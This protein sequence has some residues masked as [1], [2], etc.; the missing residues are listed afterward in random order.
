MIKVSSVLIF[1]IIFTLANAYSFQISPFSKFRNNNHLKS[2]TSDVVEISNQKQSLESPT[3]S[4]K[5]FSSLNLLQND[6]KL[7]YSAEIIQQSTGPVPRPYLPAI[8]LYN[9]V[10][11]DPKHKQAIFTI[12]EASLQWY[13]DHGGRISNLEFSAPSY[14]NEVAIE[15]GFSSKVENQMSS[16]IKLL[17]NR[18]N[19]P[20]DYVSWSSDA[21]SM[22][23][24][25]EKR[26][27]SQ[28][29]EA[30]ILNDIIGRLYHDSGDP[31]QS[32]D[33]YTKS[34]LFNPKSGST[35][36]NLG[37]AYQAIGNSQ[38]AFASF[39]QALQLNSTDPLTYLKLAFFY[40]DFATKDWVEAADNAEQCYKYYLQH[41]DPEDTSIL[42]RL[43]NLLVREHKPE[44]AIEV[45]NTIL[46]LNEG[47]Q[48]VWFNKAHAEI[49][50]GDYSAAAVSLKRTL[51]LDPGISAARHMLRALS[52]DEALAA[53]STEDE[54]VKELF[55]SY[56]QS[57]DDH[58]K[59]LLYSAPRVIRQEM[60][61]IYKAKTEKIAKEEAEEEEGE[62]EF[63][64][65]SA[66]RVFKAPTSTTL[67]GEGPVHSGFMMCNEHAL[68]S[69]V[70]SCTDAHGDSAPAVDDSCSTYT[71]FVN[72][73]LDILDL[74]CGTGLAGGW[75]KDYARTLV[76]VDLSE[77]MVNLAR[78]KML[79]Q[80]L[81]VMP[82]S[83]YLNKLDRTFDLVAAAD[84]ISY[85]GDLSDLFPK[86]FGAIKPGGHFIFTA[87]A[88]SEDSANI[89][90]GY[91]LLRNG[92]F[93]YSKSYIDGVINALEDNYSILMSRDYSPR[94][95]AGNPIPGYLYI[96]EK[97]TAV[98]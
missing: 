40:E 34:L 50:I 5:T 91:R 70:V 7:T 90:K 87:E 71:S 9:G 2:K 31:Q 1:F 76:G 29:G 82:I 45:F 92:R 55:D 64:L 62:E 47:L 43:G 56:A 54:Y 33:Y 88:I 72:R 85:I 18:V 17:Q 81:H 74:G 23:K 77:Q 53:G 42:S 46:S 98:Q 97:N 75:L 67:A 14:L 13:L 6:E 68:K 12:L 84:V 36:R 59:K 95:D 79:Y 78:K 26:L 35:F 51:D 94:L 96:V 52:D 37:S 89:E 65:L 30:D 57:Y 24:H 44:Q 61:K 25:C 11:Y 69:P 19:I 20:S 41:V 80:E 16:G 28:Q 63:D 39:Q 83:Q 60:A 3:L 22:I 21:K 4:L 49:K 32:I 66:D 27:H 58:G 73:T 86:I 15:F 8:L 48:N 10:N 93:G 38:L